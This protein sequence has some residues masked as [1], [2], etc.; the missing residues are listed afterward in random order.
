MFRH[1]G[2][3]VSWMSSMI[4]SLHSN[5]EAEARWIFEMELQRVLVGQGATLDACPMTSWDQMRHGVAG[6]RAVAF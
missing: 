4:E 6:R 3:I 2:V 1:G 5:C